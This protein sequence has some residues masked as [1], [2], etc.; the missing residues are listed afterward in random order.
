MNNKIII[1]ATILSSTFLVYSCDSNKAENKSRN[2]FNDSLKTVPIY[3]IES[4]PM[5]NPSLKIEVDNK[6]VYSA[7]KISDFSMVHRPEIKLTYEKHII[8]V[9]TMD[10]Q[11]FTSDTINV[12]RTENQNWIRVVFERASSLESYMADLVNMY[13]K[14][15]TEG[16]NFTEEQKSEELKLIRLEIMKQKE[17]IAKDFKSVQSSGFKV[18]YT[19]DP[20]WQKT[21]R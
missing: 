6:E 16:K 13:Y 18:S 12:T 5:L 4:I 3:V 10:K 2:E 7:K 9:S 17:E 8:T 15:R 14:N 19:D 1:L 11:Y 21:P 20:F